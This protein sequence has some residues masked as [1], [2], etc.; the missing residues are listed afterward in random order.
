MAEF[1]QLTLRLLRVIN[2]DR[3]HG[4]QV[5]VACLGNK[6]GF[7]RLVN[8]CRRGCNIEKKIDRCR[9]NLRMFVF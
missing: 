2:H 3:Y 1:M 8:T 4:V 5:V 6:Y 9:K 7:S